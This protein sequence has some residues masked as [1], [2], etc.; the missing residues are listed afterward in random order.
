MERLTKVAVSRIDG[1]GTLPMEEQRHKCI[2]VLILTK[3]HNIKVL[4]P[5]CMTINDIVKMRI[6][7]C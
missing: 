2:P 7:H 1:T 5:F 6:T 3:K 4:P